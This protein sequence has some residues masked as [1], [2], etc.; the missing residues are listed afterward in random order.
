[1]ECACVRRESVCR[2][3]GRREGKREREAF[4]CTRGLYVQGS[5]SLCKFAYNPSTAEFK[6]S[7][8]LVF[9]PLTARTYTQPA[10]A[11]SLCDNLI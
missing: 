1:M 10:E 4:A 5:T 6:R 9:H 7:D 2:G 3:G 8:Q 11:N